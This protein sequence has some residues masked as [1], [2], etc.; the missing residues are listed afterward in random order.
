MCYPSWNKTPGFTQAESDGYFAQLNPAADSGYEPLIDV[1]RER[2]PDTVGS[3]TYYGYRFKCR[4]KGIGRWVCLEELVKRSC[5]MHGTQ[6]G[7]WIAGSCRS[8]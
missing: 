2:H 7:D 3:Y 8:A 6:A 5:A 4:E 1:W